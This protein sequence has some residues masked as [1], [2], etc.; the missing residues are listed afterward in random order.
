MVFLKPF[1][2]TFLIEQERRDQS[3]L[4]MENLFLWNKDSQLYSQGY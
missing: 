1:Q 4:K 3:H 2:V